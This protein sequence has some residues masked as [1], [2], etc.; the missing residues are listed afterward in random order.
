MKKLFFLS[1]IAGALISTNANAQGPKTTTAPTATQ[2]T[3]SAEQQAAMLKQAKEKQVPML[4]EKAGISKEQAEKVVDVNFEIRNQAATALQGLNDADRS[5]K[6][7]ELKVTKE[8]RYSEFL[9]ADQI[10]AVYAA[11]EDMGKTAPKN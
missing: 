6:I 7:A 10:K 4:V 5:A 2:T 11:Y 3:I 1:L 8:K 9:S